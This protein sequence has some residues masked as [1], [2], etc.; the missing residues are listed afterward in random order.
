V[1]NHY[2]LIGETQ[3]KKGGPYVKHPPKGPIRLQDHGN[4][5]R[6]RNLWIRELPASDVN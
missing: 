3:H 4:P 6:Y 1:Q 2:E 5:V